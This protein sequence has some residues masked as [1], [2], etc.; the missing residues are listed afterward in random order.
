M[1][2]MNTA[3]MTTMAP[4]PRSGA[5]LA[6]PEGCAGSV[7]TGLGTARGVVDERVSDSRVVGDA[8]PGPVDGLNGP[9]LTALAEDKHLRVVDAIP[10]VAAQLEHPPSGDAGIATHLWLNDPGAND[11]GRLRR[12]VPTSLLEESLAV[13][14]SPRTELFEATIVRQLDHRP[15]ELARLRIGGRRTEGGRRLTGGA[16]QCEANEEREVQA[17]TPMPK[18]NRGVAPWLTMTRIE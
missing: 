7:E 11:R 1:T 5:G 9:E 3:I 13:A 15:E 2:T 6:A 17:A 16:D 4:V 14:G 18:V 12:R 8:H 10:P